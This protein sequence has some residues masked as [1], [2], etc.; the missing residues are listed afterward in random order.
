[1]SIQERKVREMHD[2]NVRSTGRRVVAAA[3]MSLGV[4]MVLT[5]L[6]AGERTGPPSAAGARPASAPARAAGTISLNERGNLHLTS[7]RGFTLNEQGPASGTVAGT[8][9]VHLQIVS[10]SHVTAEVSLSPRGGSISGKATASYHRGSTMAS[11]S[12]SL[13]I[14]EGTGSY[15]NARGSGLSFSGTIQKSNDAIAVRVSGKVSE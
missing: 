7:K 12:G 10:T 2:L 5:P 14:S 9:Y 11:F 15:R 13:S 4:L 1:M 3:T 6:A 8:L